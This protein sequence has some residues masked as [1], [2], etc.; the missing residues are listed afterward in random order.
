[1]INKITSSV[2]KKKL[3]KNG[4]LFSVLPALLFYSISFYVLHS[5]GY[6]IEDII[7]DPA[8]QRDYPSFIGFLSNVGNFLWMSAAAIC[9]FTVLSHQTPDKS[10]RDLIF[11]TGL[12]GLTLAADDFFLIHDRYINQSVCYGFYAITGCYMLIKYFSKILE[13]D[14]FSFF[15]AFG[16]LG[17][18]IFTD[19]VQQH[20]PVSWAVA[21][22]FEEGF[23]FTG[24]AG[25]VYYSGRLCSYKKTTNL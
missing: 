2:L 19:I 12:L 10:T 24:A 20:L 23:K 15:L 6:Q 9:F 11:L 25:F 17:L 3:I 7:R 8:Q 22:I 21:Q 16:C 14:G 5:S 13:I 4:F 18:S 1:M